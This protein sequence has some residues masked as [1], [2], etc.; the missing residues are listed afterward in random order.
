MNNARNCRS[1]AISMKRA[2]K[3]SMLLP[4]SPFT[5]EARQMMSVGGGHP[6]ERPREFFL[7][8]LLLE[9]ES[10]LNYGIYKDETKG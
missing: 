5:C 3:L 1:R 8:P 4:K 7:N 2:D 6:A 10:G 9:F